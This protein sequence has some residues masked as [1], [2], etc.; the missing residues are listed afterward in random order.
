LIFQENCFATEDTECAEKEKLFFG[1]FGVFGGVLCFSMRLL[2]ARS[3]AIGACMRSLLYVS[4]LLLMTAACAGA[5]PMGGSSHDAAADRAT[6]LQLEAEFSRLSVEKGTQAAFA[7]YLAEDAK[8]FPQGAAMISGHD[9][10]VKDLAE[11]ADKPRSTLSW[12]ADGAD[13]SGDL[14]YTWGRFEYQTT[15]KDGA[16][17]VFHGKYVSIWKRDPKLGWRVT[18]DIGNSTR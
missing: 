15:G 7:A 18:A 3:C 1:A 5:P 2:A 14:G 16:K 17:V 13:A 11:P 10:I 9:A 12:E 4:S 6:L 8:S